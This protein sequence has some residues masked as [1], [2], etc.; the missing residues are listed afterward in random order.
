M[1]CIA[2][3]EQTVQPGY[4]KLLNRPIPPGVD[5][6]QRWIENAWDLGA[7][8]ERDVIVGLIFGGEGYDAQ[9]A[10]QLRR[11]LLGTHKWIGTAGTWGV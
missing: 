8:C 1:A 11:Q 2:L 4:V 5:N 9:G 7:F 10:D 3:R 6:L